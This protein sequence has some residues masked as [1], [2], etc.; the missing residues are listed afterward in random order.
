MPYALHYAARYPAARTCRRAIGRVQPRHG[1]TRNSFVHLLALHVA[2]GHCWFVCVCVC[3][4]GGFV[5][6]LLL[7]LCPWLGMLS[8]HS[9]LTPSPT[10]RTCV[11]LSAISV[12]FL[13]PFPVPPFTPL[14][15]W[16]VL[17]HALSL[18][19]TSLSA[20]CACRRVDS[21]LSS[22]AQIQL[23]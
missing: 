20:T 8:L 19:H 4:R 18:S 21:D 23:H 22:Q 7:C 16:R 12:T 5:C 11:T 10:A 2:G 9:H 14:A 1:L 17:S 6:M 13:P 3:A 15:S